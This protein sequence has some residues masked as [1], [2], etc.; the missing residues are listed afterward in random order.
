M[1]SE[2]GQAEHVMKMIRILMCFS[3]HPVIHKWLRT[4]KEKNSS[5]NDV[6]LGL[7]LE[8]ISGVHTTQIQQFFTPI[9]GKLVT[10]ISIVKPTRC[11]SFTNYYNCSLVSFP[12]ASRWQYMFDMCLLLYVKSWAPDDGRKDRPKHVQCHAK[13]QN[14]WN[15]YI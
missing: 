3:E 8:V 2:N 1:E 10:I 7:S 12:L 15:W 6:A 5:V 13:I 14:L 9:R 11:T 4:T